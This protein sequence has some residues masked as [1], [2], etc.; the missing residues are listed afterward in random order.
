MQKTDSSLLSIEGLSARIGRQTILHDISL[1]IGR[2]ECL[3]IVGGSGAGKSCLL[4]CLMGLAKPATPFEGVLT[5]KGKKHNWSSRKPALVDRAAI[6]FVPQN[7]QA[8]LDPLKRL[9]SQWEQTLRCSAAESVSSRDISEL[10][11]ALKLKD[12]KSSYPHQ[13]S[14]GMQQRL[15]LAFALVSSPDILILDEPTSALDPL[16]ASRC[17]LRITELAARN[18]TAILIVTHDLALAARFADRTAIMNR[19]RIEEFG[20]TGRLLQDPQS[21]YGKLLSANR[22]WPTSCQEDKQH[23]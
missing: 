3:A 9:K 14:Q 6:S 7:P 22:C 16:I 19:G 4:K 10:F 18:N 15:L 12:L 8:G 2:G 11:S 1:D 5:F 23:A 20:P 13:W 17:M 21:D